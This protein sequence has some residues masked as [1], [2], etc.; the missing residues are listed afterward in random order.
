M[1][2]KSVFRVR[3][4]LVRIRIRILLLLPV[5]F[6]TSTKVKVFC[7]LLFEF[8]FTSFFNDKMSQGNYKT[9]EIKVFLTIFAWWWKDPS[10]P[11]LYSWLMNLDSAEGQKTHGCGTLVKIKQ[12][13]GSKSNQHT[14]SQ[15][16]G[17]T[18]QHFV[19]PFFCLRTSSSLLGGFLA[20]L[21]EGSL[22]LS[23]HTS[24]TLLTLVLASSDILAFS[25][26]DPWHFGTNQRPRIR[27]S[28]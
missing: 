28:D 21:L 12:N 6:K 20:T 14:L 23:W 13:T 18:S 16:H 4:I 3:D 1:F 24:W 17:R 15:S 22:R 27:T 2:L 25:V 11:N 26:P 9:V 5:T 10:D 19:L 7:F 8:T